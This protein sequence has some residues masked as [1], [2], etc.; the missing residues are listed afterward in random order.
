MKVLGGPIICLQVQKF[1]VPYSSVK[2]LLVLH[3]ILL[4]LIEIKYRGQSDQ[5][6]LLSETYLFDVT[7]W[8]VDYESP[9]GLR[10]SDLVLFWSDLSEI[11]FPLVHSYFYTIAINDFTLRSTCCSNTHV[12]TEYS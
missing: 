4:S 1:M 10:R 5:R 12:P 3:M 9:Y 11:D 7:W 6:L 2:F 8:D